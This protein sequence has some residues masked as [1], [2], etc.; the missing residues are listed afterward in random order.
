MVARARRNV[1][2]HFMSCDAV[3]AAK[4]V[5]YTPKRLV[6]R[7]MLDRYVRSGVI[8]PTTGSAY[9]IDVPS[10]DSYSNTRKRNVGVAMAL[11]A[12]AGGAVVGIMG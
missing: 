2:S 1:I 4:A 9:Y 11:L 10:Y 5:S 3:S 8:V 7:R 6:E 12:L